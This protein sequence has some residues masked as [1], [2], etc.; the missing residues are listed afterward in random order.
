[1]NMRYSKHQVDTNT[2]VPD[3]YKLNVRSAQATRD[4][5]SGT[6]STQTTSTA[7]AAVEKARVKPL[8]YNVY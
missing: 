7:G 8:S 2:G 6:T 4:S 3:G 5:I 1:M